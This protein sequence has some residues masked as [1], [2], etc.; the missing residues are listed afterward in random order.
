MY[1]IVIANYDYRRKIKNRKKRYCRSYDR[2]TKLFGGQNGYY[3]GQWLLTG[4]YFECWSLCMLVYNFAKLG[5]SRVFGTGDIAINTFH[6][7]KKSEYCNCLSHW[8]IKAIIVYSLK[9]N[10]FLDT[11][12]WWQW[13]TPTSYSIIKISSWLNPY[14]EF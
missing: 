14:N 2:S 9:A 1:S 3:D 13:I 11:N 5:C 4:R 10:I 6:V 12:V 8:D 7:I